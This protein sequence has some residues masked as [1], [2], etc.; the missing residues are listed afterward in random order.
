MVGHGGREFVDP[1]VVRFPG[2]GLPAALGQVDVLGVVETVF[3]LGQE[4]VE[5]LRHHRRGQHQGLALRG[6]VV[7]AET[8]G[9]HPFQQC[10]RAVGQQGPVAVGEPV[11]RVAAR[12]QVRD[13]F[14]E[15]PLDVGEDGGEVLGVG[16][17]VEQ[18]PD[19]G[20]RHPCAGQRP[21]LHQPQQVG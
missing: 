18:G 17:G 5:A 15:L 14:G 1:R 4:V 7:G 13:P 10:H 21:D 8:E 16:V 3:E 9:G 19:L 12:D 6:H 11:Q 2:L 20:Q